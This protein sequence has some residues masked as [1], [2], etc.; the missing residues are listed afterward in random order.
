MKTR[1]KIEELER[2]IRELEAR[3]LAVHHHH[4]HSQPYYYPQPIVQPYPYYQAPL[5][6]TTSTPTSTAMTVTSN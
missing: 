2:R 4:Y 6:Y 3:P 1:E 5:W